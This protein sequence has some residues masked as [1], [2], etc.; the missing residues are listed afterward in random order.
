MATDN[1]AITMSDGRTQASTINGNST[2]RTGTSIY[3]DIS[4]SYSGVSLTP[5]VSD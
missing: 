5:V 3:R 4:H 1:Y 2:G